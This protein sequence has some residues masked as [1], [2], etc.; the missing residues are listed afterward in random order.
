MAGP[1]LAAA[2][3]FVLRAAAR[4]T[5]VLLDGPGAM[6]AALVAYEAAPRAVRWWQVADRCPD[7]AHAIALT[8]LAL[9]P[10][11]DIGIRTGDGTAGLLAVPLLRAATLTEVG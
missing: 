2:S 4:R 10:L 7:A 11:L 6:A 3:G 1:G 9:R 8:R 5:P